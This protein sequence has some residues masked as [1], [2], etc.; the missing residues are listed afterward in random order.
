MFAKPL[1]PPITLDANV[2]SEQKEVSVVSQPYAAPAGAAGIDLDATFRQHIR[3]QLA[4]IGASVDGIEAVS[5]SKKQYRVTTNATYSMVKYN[6]MIDLNAV[7][8]FT[9]GIIV[10]I[11][12]LLFLCATFAAQPDVY[13]ARGA[14]NK[15]AGVMVRVGV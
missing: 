9:G 7:D 4:K 15:Y 5:G 3:Q 8:S 13:G 14:G 12:S 11:P 10:Q 2:A 1:L 6:P